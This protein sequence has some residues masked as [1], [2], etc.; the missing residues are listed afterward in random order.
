VAD[1]LTKTD[2]LA[3]GR[4][5]A[6]AQA[7]LVR[8]GEVQRDELV[9][10]AIKRIELLNPTL[11]AVITKAYESG[12]ADARAAGLDAPFAGVPYLLKDLAAEAKGM[13]FC[14][15]SKWLRD[16]V[17]TVDSELTKRLR[18]AGLGVL[19]KTNTPEFGMQPTTEPSL[20]GATR[21]PWNLE[22]STGGSSGGSA[23]AVASGM[24]PR[25]HANDLGGSI[26]IPASA[27]GLFGL[28]PTRARNPL[29]PVYGDAFGGWA[30]E[31]A[32][33]RSVRDSAALL[34][35]THGPDLGDPYFAPVPERPFLDEVGAPTGRLRI[36]FTQRA[37]EARPVH[38]AELCADLGHDVFER[39][40]TELTPD[41]GH[42][43]GR[44]YGAGVAWIVEYW[45]R[46]LGR[47]P[48]PDE[49][50]PITRGMYEQG[51]RVGGGELLMCVTTVQ[52][53]SRQVA[54]AYSDFDV[55]LSPT[56]SEPPPV[57]GELVSTPDDPTRGITRG[58][59]LV[60]IPLV[61]ANMTG[62]PAM[63][64]PLFWVDSGLPIGV[65]FMG[66]FG[67]EATLLRLAAQLEEARPWRDRWP[68]V[69]GLTR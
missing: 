9:E 24:V 61:I 35:A 5:D 43:I 60:A 31:H 55:W 38:P 21:N 19:G 63:S 46:I 29:G 26:R 30:V 10:A 47:S 66:H 40:L 16:N 52:A 22:R 17:S 42:A 56:L 25:A 37:P 58:A 36:A 23:A 2:V 45:T 57:L 51:K 65:H 32:V 48:E 8:A 59:D 11:N 3:L 15:G 18:R 20:F 64:V 7:A 28:K 39:D 1:Q 34:D 44:S 50:E 54:L 14:E 13:R 41:V 49:L 67:D 69:S 53:F 68:D 4:L 12:R 27:C 33:T 62:N 6:T